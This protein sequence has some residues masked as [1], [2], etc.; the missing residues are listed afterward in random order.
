MAK[1]QTV[2][3]TS[4]GTS[5]RKI[6]RQIPA[7]LSIRTRQRAKTDHGSTH[8]ILLSPT[9]SPTKQELFVT[10][11]LA[12]VVIARRRHRRRMQRRLRL[13]HKQD[14]DKEMV[15]KFLSSSET[16]RPVVRWLRRMKDENKYMQRS[17]EKEDRFLG[18]VEDDL[19]SI[20]AVRKMER[21]SNNTKQ[22][23]PLLS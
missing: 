17:M 11:W 23:V 1:D 18:S 20:L 6:R 12:H 22:D 16:K 13:L 8:S 19:N 4:T 15:Q 9:S 3:E 2:A 21:L 10:K 7:I 14:E 5:V